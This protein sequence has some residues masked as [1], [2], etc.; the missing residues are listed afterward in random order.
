M[1]GHYEDPQIP[2]SPHQMEAR[3]KWLELLKKHPHGT[4]TGRLAQACNGFGSSMAYDPLGL[5]FLSLGIA[6]EKRDGYY[7]FA[8]NGKF[9]T[10]V[11]A[12]EFRSLMGLVPS[13]HFIAGGELV[14][15]AGF[16]DAGNSHADVASALEPLLMNPHYIGTK[17]NVREL[18][19][20]V[21]PQHNAPNT[22]S[23]DSHAAA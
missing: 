19:G 4:S 14:S 6:A 15:I 2:A 11:L 5:A 17:Q 13:P 20:Y 18:T 22:H 8:M 3:A 12:P 23:V 10:K 7:G 1:N 21:D 9:Y 16:A